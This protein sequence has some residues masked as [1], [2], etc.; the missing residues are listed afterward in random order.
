MDTLC[1][2]VAAEA[3]WDFRVTDLYLQR[4]AFLLAAGRPDLVRPRW[5]ERILSWQQED[6]GWKSSW[7]SCWGP[8]VFA[9]RWGLQVPNAHTTVQGVWLFY[10]LKYRYPQWIVD[11][12]R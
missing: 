12:Y 9:S 11:N 2:R 8:G 7:Y 5:V 1:E 3:F 10:M 6:G 4:V